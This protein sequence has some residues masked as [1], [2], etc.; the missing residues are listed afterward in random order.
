MRVSEKT[1]WAEYIHNSCAYRHGIPVLLK[2]M[3]RV[4]IRSKST[5][6]HRC[7][8]SP[9]LHQPPPAC[10]YLHVP[11][12]ARGRQQETTTVS[13]LVQLCKVYVYVYEA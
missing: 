6:L 1:Q 11:N 10:R 4:I 7:Q 12:N 5:M 13:A 3:V 2:V 8:V 9:S